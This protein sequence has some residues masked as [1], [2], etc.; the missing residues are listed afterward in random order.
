MHRREDVYP[1]P[2]RFAPE[3]FLEQSAGTYTW[4]PFGGG[5]RRCLGASFALYEMRIVLQVMARRLHLRAASPE[6]E[7]TRRRAITMAPGRGGEV[8]AEAA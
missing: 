3:R 2:L 1:E 4:F 7:R 5:V 8:V 6:R